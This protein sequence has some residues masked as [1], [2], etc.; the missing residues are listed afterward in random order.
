[1]LLKIDTSAKRHTLALSFCYND[2]VN[3]GL[4]NS[5]NVNALLRENE[6]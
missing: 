6:V 3:V 5:F 4:N 1:M 2:P